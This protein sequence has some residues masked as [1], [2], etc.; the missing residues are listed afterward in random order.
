MEEGVQFSVSLSERPELLMLIQQFSHRPQAWM[1]DE[2][3]TRFT[4]FNGWSGAESIRDLD[5]SNR[6]QRRL[7]GL[8]EKHFNL[9]PLSYSVF[10]RPSNRFALL[11]PRLLE[12]LT[13]QT[14]LMRLSPMLAASIHRNRVLRIIE[15]IGEESYREAISHGP[16]TVGA[17]YR[18]VEVSDSQIENELDPTIRSIGWLGLGQALSGAPEGILQRTFLKFASS[19]SDQIEKGAKRE[20]R[21]HGIT[22]LMLRILK[23]H[24]NRRA[25]TCVF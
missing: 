14:G 21:E 22:D 19:V 11:S 23:L 18:G 12:R 20:E 3:W 24:V 7:A 25:A 1:A 17:S 16:L 10:V 9:D 4:T 2:Y 6:S 13:Y 8:I 15:Q 5:E